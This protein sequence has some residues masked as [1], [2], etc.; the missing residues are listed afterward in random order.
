[1]KNNFYKGRT[2]KINVLPIIFLT[3]F[4]FFNQFIYGE[5]IEVRPEN[6][7]FNWISGN[8]N[9]ALAICDDDGT[10]IQGPEW[11]RDGTNPPNCAYIMG[12]SAR[13]IQVQFF[14]PNYQGNM[15]LII[16][17]TI[18][19]GQG[20]GTVCNFF[21]PDYD[22]WNYIKLDLIG[23]LP[24]YVG[25]HEFT[26]HWDI[27]AIPT[28]ITS[29]CAAHTPTETT[30]I[31]Y[32]L[33]AAPQAPVANP[34]TSVLDLACT[35]AANN[36][37]EPQ[38][39][40]NITTNAYSYF[41]QTKQYTGG[42]THTNGTAFSLSTFLSGTTAD[43]MD[44][45]A[46]VQVFTWMLGGTQTRVLVINNKQPYVEDFH[47]KK[48]KPIGLDWD[49][50]KLWS[51]HQVGWLDNVYDACIML[52]NNARVPVNEAVN[53]SYKDDLYLDINDSINYPWRPKTSS[54]FYFGDVQ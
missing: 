40:S 28:E 1:M 43:C 10:L 52:Y 2:F 14:S 34:W 9:D 3:L 42:L 13:Q 8:A 49:E 48:I 32:T 23:E 50:N 46:V 47:Y 5:N 30:H 11:T 51:F 20:I 22:G 36:T 53:G 37:T 17:L 41:G 29:Y 19:N 12:Q 21:V 24:K 15:H 39:L 27:Y 31:Y 44:M 33:L 35:W 54:V 6:I 4:C 45:S 18:S 26:W 16:N 25:R 7:Q 38:V